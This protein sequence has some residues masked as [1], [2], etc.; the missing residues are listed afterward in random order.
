MGEIGLQLA[1]LLEDVAENDNI[2]DLHLTIN[3][4]PYIREEGSLKPYGKYKNKLDSKT[5]K[6]FAEEMMGI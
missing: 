3:S 6:E 2:S 1:N 4:Q 5:L